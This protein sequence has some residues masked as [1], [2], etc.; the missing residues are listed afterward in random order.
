[1]GERMDASGQPSVRVLRSRRSSHE[2]QVAQNSVG[3]QSRRGLHLK[4]YARDGGRSKTR[5]PYR[6]LLPAEYDARRGRATTAKTVVLLFAHDGIARPQ[7]WAQLLDDRRPSA[8]ASALATPG[9]CG[10]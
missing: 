9:E 7:A 8:L 10:W 2:Q 4:A 6:R 3:A 5:K 1:M